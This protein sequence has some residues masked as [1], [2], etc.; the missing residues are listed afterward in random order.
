MEAENMQ[1]TTYLVESNSVG[2]GSKVIGL[3][4]TGGT[5]GTATTTFTGASGTYDVLLRYFDENDGKAILTT[6][7][8]GIQ[9]DGRTLD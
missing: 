7:I 5:N 3:P 8:G 2:S 6:S 4:K 1:L 9:V